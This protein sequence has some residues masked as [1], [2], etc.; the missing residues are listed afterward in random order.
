MEWGGKNWQLKLFLLTAL[1][2]IL[3]LLKR[4]DFFYILFLVLY[5]WQ[6]A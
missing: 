6:L 3:L 1:Q 5:S 2:Y 4:T